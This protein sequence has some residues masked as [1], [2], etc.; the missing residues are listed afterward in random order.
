MTAADAPTPEFSRIVELER[1]GDGV[2][3]IEAAQEE[4]AALARRFGLVS[5]ARL[6]ADL[7]LDPD[8][9]AVN[10]RGTMQADFVQ[11][12]AVSGDDLPVSLTEPLSL[13]FVR[14]ASHAPDEEVEL[15][16]DEC[17]EIEYEGNRFD[18]GEAVSQ[19]LGLAIDP[20]ATGPHADEVRKGA[21][22]LDEQSSGP[23]AA[24]AALKKQ[25]E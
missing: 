3:R 5:I 13:R 8:G 11:S 9:D 24:L 10:A 17:D 1:L 12:C 20:F 25:G 14:P 15:T 2:R 22:L 6:Q 16:A 19:S 4:R 21:R 18:L 7:T 23:F